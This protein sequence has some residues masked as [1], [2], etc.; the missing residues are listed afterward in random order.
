VGWLAREAGMREPM[1]GAIALDMWLTPK[2]RICMDL[3]NALKVMIDA[4]K[5]VAYADDSQIEAITAAKLPPGKPGML[6]W[7][8]QL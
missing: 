5:G 8:R 4:L 6:V 2:N 3:D 1:T 7:L